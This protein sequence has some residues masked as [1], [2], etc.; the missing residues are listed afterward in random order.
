MK[1]LKNLLPETASVL[2]KL[3]VSEILSDYTFVGGSALALYL[4]HRYSED[5]DLFTWKET[6]DFDKI[7]HEIK[8]IKSQSVNILN[9]TKTQINL[10]IDGI[11]V[12]F[13]ANNWNELKNRKQLFD[14]LYIA[15]IE[16]LAV[17]KV[18]TLFLRAK[19][20]DYYDLY[21]LNKTFFSLQQLYDMTCRKMQN[22]TMALFQKALTFTADIDDENIN[23]LQPKYPVAIDGIEEHFLKEIKKYNNKLKI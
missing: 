11:N 18:N 16:T 8:K 1:D 6:I 20:R 12:T 23:H 13:F 10:V 5:I 14:N 21:V 15:N 3:A 17:M 19:F 9:I 4:N 7:N 2:R 22:L